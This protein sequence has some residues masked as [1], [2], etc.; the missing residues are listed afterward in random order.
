LEL[1]KNEPDFDALVSTL[2]FLVDCPSFSILSPSPL[3]SQIV[4]V[5]VFEIVPNYWNILQSRKK[6]KLA[7]HDSSTLSELELVLS[8]LRSVPG[9]NSVLLGLK[10][11][12]QQSKESKKSVGGPNFEELLRISLQLLQALLESPKTV[13]IIWRNI[14]EASHPQLTQKTVW[15]EFL[16]LVGGGKIP[17][18]AAEAEDLVNELSKKVGEKYWIADGSLFSSW[19]AR[20]LTFWTKNLQ[21]DSENASKCCG[22]LLCKTLRLGYTGQ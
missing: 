12:V 2:L 20:N 17:S 14:Y 13:E 6:S 15:N 19:L 10:Q 8:C 21:T 7:K 18:I 4:H 9:I 3:A 5:L 22:A 1:L 16:S 11:H